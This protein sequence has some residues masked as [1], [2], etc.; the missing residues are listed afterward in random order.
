[1]A[2]LSTVYFNGKRYE[3]EIIEG[4]TIADTAHRI[5]AYIDQPC[6]GLGSC[7]KCRVQVNGAL[8][9]PSRN[10]LEHISSEDLKRGIRLAC[11]TNIS[12]GMEITTI[13][14]EPNTAQILTDNN[15]TASV[16]SRADDGEPLCAAIDIGTT[17]LVVYILR[18]SD[19]R[20]LAAVSALNPQT[21]FGADVI[22][23]ISHADND[24]DGLKTMQNVL[25]K[26]LNSMLNEALQNVGADISQIAGVTV[27]GNTTMEHIFAGVSPSTIGKAPFMPQYREFPLLNASNCGL[28]CNAPLHMLPCVSG[29][30]GGDIVAG[31]LATGMLDS[32]NVS[33]LV[34]IGTNNEMVLGSRDFLLCCSAAAGPAFEGAKISCGMRAASGAIDKVR[35]NNSGDI[36]ISTIGGTEP[37]GICGSGLIDAVA[38]LVKANV[39]Q[40]SGR[41]AKGTSLPGK[42]ANRLNKS[43]DGTTFTLYAN[44]RAKI[45]SLSQRDI[46]EVQLAKSA[47]ATGIEIMLEEA[48]LTLEDVSAIHVAGAFGNYLDIDS[49]VSLGIIPN[50]PI[51]KI[52]TAGNSAGAGARLAAADHTKWDDALQ[53]LDMARHIEL[54]SHKDFQERFVQNLS[55]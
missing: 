37:R 51:S 14:N 31:I 40:R 49:A 47:I 41:F 2:E 23:R 26:Q 28:N 20:A 34:D 52:T 11:Q 53:I 5:G 44:D 36:E 48:G 15:M 24:K 35:L 54:A 32:K 25:V 3:T 50:V 29:F 10:E 12:P 18:A 55:L 21:A 6:S 9:E 4:D 45:I 43:E 38:L 19:E 13:G 17:T 46:R 39:I 42:L 27:A 22:S 8:S 1:M 16:P 33:L 7:G 30:V